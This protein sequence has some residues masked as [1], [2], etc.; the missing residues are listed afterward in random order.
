MAPYTGTQ[1]PE[2]QHQ[3]PEEARSSLATKR[4]TAVCPPNLSR[5]HPAR[6]QRTPGRLPAPEPIIWTTKP[7]RWGSSQTGRRSRASH[8]RTSEVSQLNRDRQN[9]WT[10]VIYNFSLHL[11]DIL[12][13]CH[14][15]RHTNRNIPNS[16]LALPAVT[17]CLP[18]RSCLCITGANVPR[19]ARAGRDRRRQGTLSHGRRL[20]DKHPQPGKIVLPEGAM[21][22]PL[23]NIR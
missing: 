19:R 7:P 16:S 5:D 14:R 11:M 23:R 15:C 20:R 21:G 9:R 22:Q 10:T 1:T 17:S 13:H 2:C 4:H 12:N 8:R 18:G 6:P 3:S